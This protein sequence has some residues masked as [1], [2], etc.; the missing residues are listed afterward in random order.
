MK[1]INVYFIGECIIIV[2]LLAI[3]GLLISDRGTSAETGIAQEVTVQEQ[4]VNNNE[5]VVEDNSQ[6][7]GLKKV[8]DVILGEEDTTAVEAEQAAAPVSEIAQTSTV[9]EGKKIV[10]FGDSIWND[11]RGTDGVSEQLMAIFSQL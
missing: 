11:A 10:V 9:L 2:L 6:T 7:S 8:A 5:V 1:K 3:I 4:V